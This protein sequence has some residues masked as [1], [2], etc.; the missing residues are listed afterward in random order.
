M[1]IP[2]ILEHKYA[3]MAIKEF[4]VHSYL[5]YELDNPIVSDGEFDELENFICDN[6]SWIKPYDINGYLSENPIMVKGAGGSHLHGKV[7]GQT[8]DYAEGLLR[9]HLREPL[10]V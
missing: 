5:Y 4:A 8:K 7:C 6:Y 1:Q 9:E 10:K 2:K 3:H